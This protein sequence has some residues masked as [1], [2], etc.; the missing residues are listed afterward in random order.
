MRSINSLNGGNNQYKSKGFKANKS[1]KQNK[2]LID[3]NINISQK[4]KL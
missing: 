2:K 3:K 4:N 1:L